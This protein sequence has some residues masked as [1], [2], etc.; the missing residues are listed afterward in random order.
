MFRFWYLLAI[1]SFQKGVF[2]DSLFVFDYLIK[3]E[4]AL[5]IFEYW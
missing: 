5:Y 4:N 1:T 3:T 2:C